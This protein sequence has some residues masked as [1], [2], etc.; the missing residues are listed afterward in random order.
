MPYKV[1]VTEAAHADLDDALGYI[2]AT[3]SNPVAAAS[4]LV[5]VDECYA[6]LRD[7]PMMFEACRDARLRAVGYRRAVIDNFVLVYR[8]S[9]AEE[10][11]FVLR[12]FYGGR[13]YE[14]LI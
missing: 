11:V 14:K 13:D 10:A 1:F 9:E 7:Y 3:L 12:F 8:V 6:Q 5:K 4:L 2:A